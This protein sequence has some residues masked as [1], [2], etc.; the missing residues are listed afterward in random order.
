M[1]PEF[2]EAEAEQLVREINK[3]QTRLYL[4]EESHAAFKKSETAHSELQHRYAELEEKHKRLQESHRVLTQEHEGLQ[5]A[6]AAV[7]ASYSWRITTPLR[8]AIRILR[9]NKT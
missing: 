4:L 6:F 1:S 7:L 8:A 5:S 3:R 9:G 2:Q